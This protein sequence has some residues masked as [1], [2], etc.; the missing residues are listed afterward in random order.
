[1]AQPPPRHQLILF[2][3]SLAALPIAVVV[4]LVDGWKIGGGGWPVT[5]GFDSTAPAA[6]ALMAGLLQGALLVLTGWL[7]VGGRKLSPSAVPQSLAIWFLVGGA[8]TGLVNAWAAFA[9][10][11]VMTPLLAPVLALVICFALRGKVGAIRARASSP[12][13]WLLLPMVLIAIVGALAPAVQ[14]DGLR[15]HL[16]APHS[17]LRAGHF[18]HLPYQAHSNLPALQGIIAGPWFAFDWG[19]RVYQLVNALH[20]A[21]L[22]IMAGEISR[23]AWRA[24]ASAPSQPGEGTSAAIAA[25]STA[26]VPVIAIVGS[27]P[28]SDV[29]SAAYFAAAVWAMLPGSLRSQRSRLGCSSLLLGTAC[30]AKLS[31]LPIAV[32]LGVC[33]LPVVWNAGR[34][35]GWMLATALFILPGLMVVGPWLL[36]SAIYHGN[37]VYPAAY[38]VFGGPEWS[39]FNDAFYKDKSAEKGFG[40][41]PADLLKSPYNITT[42]W[43]RFEGQNPGPLLLGLLPAAVLLGGVLLLRRWRLTPALVLLPLIVIGWLLWFYGYQSVRFLIPQIVVTIA[44]GVPALLVVAA[45][46]PRPTLAGALATIVSCAMVSF[47]WP[48][49]Y[50][51]RINPSYTAA[52]GMLDTGF[53][54]TRL[55]LNSYPAI[56]WLNNN[57]EEDETV[58]YIGEHRTAYARKYEPMASDWFDTP[59]ILAEIQ[60]T[61]SNQTLLESWRGQGIR[62]ILL[63]LQ[64]LGLY[65][66]LYFKPRFSTEEWTRFEELRT[67]LISKS[68]YQE[69]NIYVAEL[70]ED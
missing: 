61:D 3:L 55:G 43:P 63:N 29:A 37:P 18:V 51:L 31:V 6:F 64:E 57:T 47:A 46:L 54:V 28:F 32:L 4:W 15:Y 41:S 24:M 17:W 10:F 9:Y 30:A 35:R 56:Q 62:Y 26:S 25:I 16:A 27:W 58:L 11:G 19:Y 45:R 50:Q 33:L 1:M 34:R 53:Y 23:L 42:E 44:L 8:G 2:A 7:L 14:S 67:E 68:V 66:D 69:S 22:A 49:W 21:A 20:L 40:K 39:D 59:Y 48:V 65:E 36:K 12:V 52:F 60:R 38:S 70:K 13:L 5:S